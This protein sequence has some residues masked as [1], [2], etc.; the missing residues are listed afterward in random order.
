MKEMSLKIQN[1]DRIPRKGHENPSFHNDENGTVN[2]KRERSKNR[3]ENGNTTESKK[4]MVGFLELFR[5]ADAFDIVLMIVG[6]ICA[7]ING[8]GLPVGF[9]I[10]GQMMD[11]FIKNSITNSSEAL[12]TSNN[13]CN[14]SSG[15][16]IEAEMS[17]YAWY[18][19]AIGFTV[20]LMSFFQVWTFSLAAT[21]QTARIRHKFFYAILHQEMSWFDRAKTGTLNSR[22]TD[23]INTI[24]DGL[25]DKVSMFAQYLSNFV[26][27]I[28]I[29]FVYGWKLTLVILSICP[30][31]AATAAVSSKVLGSL[32]AKEI[33]ASA[34]SGAVAEEVLSAIRTVVAF[35]GQKKALASY[36]VN[37]HHA[38][39][40]SMRKALATYLSMGISQLLTLSTYGLGIW[41]GTKLTVDE[42]DIYTIGRVDMIFLAVT[43]GSFTFGQTAPNVQ[44]VASARVAAYEIYKII[45]KKRDIDSS[46]TDGHKPDK[47]TGRIEFKNI[48][49]SYPTRPDVHIL[50][51]LNLTVEPGKTMALVGSSGSGKSTTIQLL[52]RFYDPL[53]GE[54]TLDGHDLRTL[55][56]KWLRE[57]IGVVSQEPCLFGTTIAENICY[58][59]EDVT[60]SEIQ[61]AAIEANAYD[62]ISKLPEK[63]N[64]VV[65]A[66]GAQ[67][68]GGQKQRIAIARALVRNPKI[69]LLDEATSALDTQSEAIVQ[70]ALDKARAGRTTILIAHR[71]S[72]VKTADIIAG[73]ENGIVI[74][75]G[76][77][78]ELMEKKGVYYSLVMQQNQKDSDEEEEESTEIETDDELSTFDENIQAIIPNETAV[79]RNSVV[80]TLSKISR[81]KSSIKK[82]KCKKNRNPEPEEDLPEVPLTKVL[83]WN[84]PEWLYLIMCLIASVI[85]GGVWPTFSLLYGKIVGAFRE[86]DGGKRSTVTSIISLMFFVMGI[87]SLFVYVI[88]GYTLG[89]AGGNLTMRLRSLSFKALLRQEIG[90]FDDRRNDVGIWITRLA[91]D[92]SQA[93]GAIGDRLFIFS[94]TTSTLLTAF[95]IS[96]VYG[97]QLTLLILACTPFMVGSFVI[98]SKSL[99]GHASENQAAL[100]EAGMISTEA[101]ENIRT[102]ASLTREDAFYEKYAASLKKPYRDARKGGPVNGLIYGMSQSVNFFVTAIVCRFGAWLIVNCYT[103]FENI[104]IVYNTA[105]FSAISIGQYS[106]LAP[107]FGKAKIAVQR[108]A[109]LF[110]RKPLIDS[111]SEDGNI[112]DN[113]SGDIEFKDT[114]FV[115]P[116]RPKVQVLQGL[117]IRVK[118][119][120]TLALVGTSGCGKSTTI[121]LLQRFYD[122]I[123]GH[124]LADGID[125][126][127][128]NLQWFRS[129]L[130]IVS[131]EPVLFDCSIAENI[132][133]GDNSRIVSEEEIEEAAKAAN[134]HNFIE[135]LPEKYNTHVGD[136][137]AQ[138][139]GG[140]K[141]RI[142]IARA[143]VRKPKVLLLDEATSA[144]DTES[145]Q[146]VQ[147]ALDDA[148]QG[149]TCI[150]IAHRLS[151]V[152][153]ADVIAVIHLGKVVEQ[154][155]HSELLAKQG[156]Y[157]DLVNAQ[158]SH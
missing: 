59:R 103:N 104:F 86:T 146:I 99:S 62:F 87:I 76:S 144:L 67:L 35:N 71:L 130:G 119:G 66:K 12:P 125:T 61:Q 64:T 116:T 150:V 126:K 97:W 21:R 111:Y 10:F 56:V 94:L 72:T 3:D 79:R 124:V 55:N 105:L 127:S 18:F 151:T 142:A 11:I 42:S 74:E 48:Y 53:Q 54:V 88:I 115:Y 27:G 28:V 98:Q 145:E 85:A 156:I 34:K 155:T 52:Q 13:E 84:K 40:F 65:G 4:I 92:A 14:G 22:L 23:D 114:K 112:L 132:Q 89:K 95:I 102:V 110:E 134:I 81:R 128:L 20:F 68:S 32:A 36:E 148:R 139:S 58:G 37:L 46:S 25:G 96:F 6:L 47:F 157:Y 57:K 15:I 149:R 123:D 121:Q 141:Q 8:L 63:F 83:G 113:F 51:G 138:L 117:N 106:V 129:Q 7:L 26:A 50:K 154:G 135:T 82:R 93:K 19:A 16:D 44:S 17:K 136:K 38:K 108:I 153:N 33:S 147:R 43:M 91:T 122:P 70:E 137:G 158:V 143:L 5:F 60:N 80:S 118:K 29:G 120:Q 101:V 30:L 41:Y 152:K 75:Q 131:Q 69:L 31:L 73:F 2:G 49:F 133:Y 107:D 9:I 39:K 140:Q 45:Q 109:K 77:H 1:D 100:E 78:S 90:W 24:R